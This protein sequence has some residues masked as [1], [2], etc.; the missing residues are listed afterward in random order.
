MAIGA[1]ETLREMIKAE[2]GCT[3]SPD[4]CDFYQTSDIAVWEG[5]T[6]VVGTGHCVPLVQQA[7]GA[8]APTDLWIKGPGVKGNTKVPAGTAIATFDAA[9]RYANARTGNHA[10]I[11][12]ATSR[13]G[14]VVVDQYLGLTRPARRTLRFGNRRNWPSNDGDAFHVVLTLKVMNSALKTG[15]KWFN[16]A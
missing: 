4:S 16:I 14:L 15:T 8:P 2:E 7:T 3:I 10:A 5:R 11:F 12:V 1:I 13:D 6:S 9:G